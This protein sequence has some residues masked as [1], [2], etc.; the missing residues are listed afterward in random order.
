MAC[1]STRV[2]RRFVAAG[3]GLVGTD[4]FNVDSSATGTTH[5]HEILLGADV[6]IV[7]NL[8]NLTDLAR[9]VTGHTVRCAFVPLRLAGIDGS[10]IRAF[11]W[12]E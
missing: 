8:A 2:T 10:P 12:T 1:R 6:L 4:A 3:A 9:S 11:A 7:E 5:A